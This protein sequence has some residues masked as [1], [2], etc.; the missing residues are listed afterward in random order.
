MPYARSRCAIGRHALIARVGRHALIARIGRHAPIARVGRHA[1]IARVGRHAPIAR[2]GR[3]APIA[4]GFLNFFF[5]Y[6]FFHPFNVRLFQPEEIQLRADF[7]FLRADLRV[8][9]ALVAHLFQLD[10]MEL[11]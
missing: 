5:V 11:I 1:L 3:H 2:I 9:V 6:L 10:F 7:D 8:I 4:R